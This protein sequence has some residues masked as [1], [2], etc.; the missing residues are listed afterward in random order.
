MLTAL[1]AGEATV[2]AAGRDGRAVNAEGVRHGEFSELKGAQPCRRAP[3]TPEMRRGLGVAAMIGAEVR[4]VTEQARRA[5]LAEGHLRTHTPGARR[6]QG[7]PSGV[8]DEVRLGP[9]VA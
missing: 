6:G 5:R 1:R 3:V 4:L 7:E 8:R 2:A 9:T